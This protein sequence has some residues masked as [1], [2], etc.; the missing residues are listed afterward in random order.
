ML[1]SVHS[2]PE[3]F[4]EYQYV[5]NVQNG[6]LKNIILVGDEFTWQ[7][8]TIHSL[9]LLNGLDFPRSIYI[10]ILRFCIIAANWDVHRHL[11][12]TVLLVKSATCVIYGMAVWKLPI[13][14]K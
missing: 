14:L 10:K 1:W 13:C 9:W 5:V 12:C 4:Q 3:G 6:R 7:Y 8:R 11:L 2:Q